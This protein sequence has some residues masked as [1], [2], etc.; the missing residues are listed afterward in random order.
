MISSSAS[1]SNAHSSTMP[2]RRLSTLRGTPLTVERVV[3]IL[4]THFH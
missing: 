2:N 1:Q 4:Q 3:L